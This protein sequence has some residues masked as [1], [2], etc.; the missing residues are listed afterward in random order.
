FQLAPRW[1]VNPQR[2]DSFL[3]ALP[4]RHRYTFE[5]RS[6][7]WHTEAVYRILR[8]HNAAFC[9]YEL[10]G[11]HSPL[12][13]TADFSYVRLHGPLGRYQGSYSTETLRTWAQRIAEWR[14]KL[15]HIYI[16]FDNDQE[17]FA[18]RNALELKRLVG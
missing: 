1:N 15:K 9:I 17:A 14:R 11:F 8:A 3:S 4:T 10:A 16:Y 2:L 18:A 7:T 5:F 13:I 12:E 6:T